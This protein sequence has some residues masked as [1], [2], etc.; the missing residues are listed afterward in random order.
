MLDT[1]KVGERSQKEKCLISCSS[2][3]AAKPHC[4]KSSIMKILHTIRFLCK[5]LISLY[6][7]YGII[8]GFAPALAPLVYQ[9]KGIL[10]PGRTI[11]VL[12]HN[13]D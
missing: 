5:S 12:R 2:P 10:V 4:K 1:K 9:E 3:E 6:F 11:L 13:L 8:K 7:I